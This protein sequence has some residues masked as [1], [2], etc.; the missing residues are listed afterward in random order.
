MN[1]RIVSPHLLAWRHKFGL[2]NRE[3]AE[4]TGVSRPTIVRAEN[5]LT[6]T[7]ASLK[8]IAQALYVTPE[9][10]MVPPK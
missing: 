8:R 4:R 6:I 3:M 10:L 9:D 5:G 2:T 7:R 1:G